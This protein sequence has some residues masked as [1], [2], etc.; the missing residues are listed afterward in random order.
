M[1]DAEC[2]DQQIYIGA[3]ERHQVTVPNLVAGKFDRGGY[4]RTFHSIPARAMPSY[5][6]DPFDFEYSPWV[7][8]AIALDMISFELLESWKPEGFVMTDGKKKK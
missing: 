6:G 2:V 5:E 8:G 4:M 1:T 3:L 7:A